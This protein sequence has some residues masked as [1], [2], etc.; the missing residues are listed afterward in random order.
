MPTQ[1]KTGGIIFIAI[2]QDCEHALSGPN[3]NTQ[4]LETQSLLLQACSAGCSKDGRHM[5][6]YSILLFS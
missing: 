3:A 4:R 5:N 2:Q 6:P 1:G